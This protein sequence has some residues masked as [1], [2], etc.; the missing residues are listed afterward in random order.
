MV[1]SRDSGDP[2][3]NVLDLLRKKIK[4]NTADVDN[5]PTTITTSQFQALPA[6]SASNITACVHMLKVTDMTHAKK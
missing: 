6:L 1:A 4:H 3:D 2:L 5:T